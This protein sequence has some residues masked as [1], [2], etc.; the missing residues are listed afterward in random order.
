MII[1][2]VRA[3]CEARDALA[4]R[5]RA[6]LGDAGAQ[7][8]IT[9]SMVC[10]TILAI[11][12]RTGG[13][14]RVVKPTK[15]PVGCAHAGLYWYP[16]PADERG[17]RCVDCDWRPGEPPG[18]SPQHDRSH[19]QLKAWCILHDMHESG[20]VFVSNSSEGDSIAAS[21]ADMARASR[22]YD[23][24]SIARIILERYANAEHVQYWRSIGDGIVAGRDPRERCHCG[25]L[26]TVFTLGGGTRSATCSEHWEL[27]DIKETP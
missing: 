21:T 13:R 11:I 2:K 26:A 12:D 5:Q 15:E 10:Q 17:W 3:Y 18:F 16:A 20:I 25:A 4:Q 22:R 23:S 19:L 9:E 1:D 27:D 14:P 7:D 8:H 24:A 6:Q